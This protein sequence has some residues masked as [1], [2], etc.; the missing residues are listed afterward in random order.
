MANCLLSLVYKS[1]NLL[2]TLFDDKLPSGM[3]NQDCVGVGLNSLDLC[4][5]DENLPRIHLG[6][7]YQYAHN[8]TFSENF[9][10]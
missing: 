9:T 6:K 2:R 10:L 8:F 1:V 5:I 4:T 3:Q 7:F